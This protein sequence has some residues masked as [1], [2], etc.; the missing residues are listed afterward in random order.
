[1]EKVFKAYYVWPRFPSL[2]LSGRACSLSC[3]HCNRVYLRDMIDVSSPDKLIKVCRELKER[4]AVGVLLSGGCRRDGEMMNLRKLLPAIKRVKEETDLIIKLHTGIVDRELAEGI[5][6]AGVDIASVEVVG[7]ERV[8]RDVFGMGLKVDD[9]R[10]TLENLRDAG[11]RH[12]VPHVCIGLNAGKLDG[13]FRAIDL[14]RDSV[15]PSVFVL[16]VLKP[17]K[18]TEFED[19]KIP[20]AG[21]VYRV[22]RYAKE[23]FP[24]IDISLGCMRPRMRG[25]VEIERVCLLAGVTRM[26]IPARETLQMAERMGYRIRRIEACCALPEEYEGKVLE[27]CGS[28]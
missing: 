12:I 11:I 22:A 23:S 17:T 3:K 21:D 28:G 1:M 10:K 14:V 7:S 8:I 20:D 4:G 27:I 24:G 25:R 26:E 2:S 18:G 9:Y 5:A 16:I 6:G 13:E 19:V 15:K